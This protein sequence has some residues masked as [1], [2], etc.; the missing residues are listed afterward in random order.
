MCNRGMRLYLCGN[1]MHMHTF[2]KG[3]D[4]PNPGCGR[5]WGV[6]MRGWGQIDWRQFE[7]AVVMC[8]C[9]HQSSWDLSSLPPNE[10]VPDHT[11]V[12]NPPLFFGHFTF[13]RPTHSFVRSSENYMWLQ[14]I[15][16]CHSHAQFRD[17]SGEPVWMTQT[18][19]SFSNVPDQ[20]W[21]VW[22]WSSTTLMNQT[23]HP[24]T[25]FSQS[26]PTQYL[27]FLSDSLT[28]EGNCHGFTPATI[29]VERAYSI[30]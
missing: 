24:P 3:G 2:R 8:D 16:D 20:F 9:I 17:S 5:E 18:V 4:T 11:I 19:H 29:G 1:V 13:P 7:D 30:C 14:H 22:V 25:K 6:G 23:T 10:T 21:L 26:N 12:K 28:E 27:P 15:L